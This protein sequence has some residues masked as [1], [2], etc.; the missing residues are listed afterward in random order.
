MNTRSVFQFSNQELYLLGS[1]LNI[2][3]LVGVHDPY[4]GWLTEEIQEA[5]PSVQQK[6]T[7]R[8]ILHFDDE[9][10]IIIQPDLLPVLQVIASPQIIVATNCMTGIDTTRYLTYYYASDQVVRLSEE[11]TVY[12]LE[13]TDK[14]D[15]PKQILTWWGIS[16]ESSK[17]YAAF[18]IRR[19]FFDQPGDN[20]GGTVKS[21]SHPTSDVV[22]ALQLAFVAA[23]KSPQYKI[24]LAVFQ[25]EELYWTVRD[26]GI[27]T[28][29]SQ[30][31]ILKP[32]EQGGDEIIEV[33]PVSLS[34]LTRYVED[35][36]GNMQPTGNEKAGE[37][38]NE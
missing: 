38:S 36:I 8:N 20:T 15:V 16:L 4:Y 23:V 25:A 3:V 34:Q 9:D 21:F 35:F 24:S 7:Q 37:E 1:L 17:S 32:I 18:N 2:P 31:W 26:L 27:I 29:Q 5:L 6:L 10:I 14:V 11:S 13:L 30:I 19:S 33:V 28:D 12:S 22:T